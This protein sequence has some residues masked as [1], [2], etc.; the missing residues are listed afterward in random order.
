MNDGARELE[1]ALG[2]LEPAALDPALLTR[3]LTSTG[4]DPTGISAADSRLEE[5]LR[6]HPPAALPADLITRLEALVA[7][8]SFPLDEKI[9]LFPKAAAARRQ[10]KRRSRQPMLAAAAA[11]ALCGAAT[12]LLIP[13]GERPVAALSAA[14][15]LPDDGPAPSMNLPREVLPAS[16][17]R[18]LSGTRDEGVVWHSK[19]HSHRLVRVEFIDRFTVRDANGK[20]VEFEQPRVEYLLVPEPID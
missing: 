6:R 15:A 12:A 11:V 8:V 14:R 3:L 19:E 13:S 16:F 20:V 18:G 1:A 10:P 17:A 9:V 7:E 2:V 5:D 4:E